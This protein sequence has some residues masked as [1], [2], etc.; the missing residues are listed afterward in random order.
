MKMKLKTYFSVALL[1]LVVGLFAACSGDDLAGNNKSKLPIEEVKGVHFVIDEPKLGAASR[2]SMGEDGKTNAKTRTY[3]KH[4]IGGGA[5][6]YWSDNDKVWV[7]D[8]H[9]D[10]KQSIATYVYNGGDRATFILPG[11]ESDYDD[12]CAVAYTLG[13]LNYTWA[14]MP[15]VVIPHDQNQVQPNDFSKAGEWGD[16]GVGKAKK[17]TGKFDFTLTHSPSYL[18]LLPRCTNANFGA[19]IEL[20]GIKINGGSM[21]G[22]S[23][24]YLSGSGF[25]LHED[26]VLDFGMGSPS[27]IGSYATEIEATVNNFPLT[28]IATNIETNGCYF[29]I[30]PGTRDL[31]ITYTIKDKITGAKADIKKELSNVICNPGEVTDITA[32]LNV[33]RV[34]TNKYYRWDADEPYDIG[35]GYESSLPTIPYGMEGATSISD[36]FLP[37]ETRS[38]TYG[39]GPGDDPRLGKG[40]WPGQQP[41]VVAETNFFKNNVPNVNEAL[42]YAFKGDPHWDE[43]T[44]WVLHNHLYTG[45]MWFKKKSKICADEGITESYMENGFILDQGFLAGQ[46]YTYQDY[47]DNGATFDNTAASINTP[48]TNTTDYFFLPALGIYYR[49]LDGDFTKLWLINVGKAGHY[50]TTSTTT[51]DLSIISFIISKGKASVDFR[52]QGLGSVLKFQ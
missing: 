16:C 48:L 25:E 41:G 26:G 1:G 42:W 46:Y 49:G 29:V 44:P 50:W 31:E 8:R 3:I 14:L 33:T 47:G 2:V 18:C 37:V 35:H 10:W 4:T 11:D 17:K 20:V 51:W 22:G 40:C 9:G 21:A 24:H 45:G 13:G 12:N 6:A 5:D 30:K 28:N 15:S 52:G 43:T 27:G 19:N 32:D 38:Y 36:S 39:L 34:Y 23:N 7:K